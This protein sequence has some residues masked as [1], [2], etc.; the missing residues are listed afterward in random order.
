MCTSLNEFSALILA[1]ALCCLPTKVESLLDT[2]VLIPSMFM[3][4]ETCKHVGSLRG[5]HYMEREVK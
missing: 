4:L 5:E 1:A 2:K 3:K